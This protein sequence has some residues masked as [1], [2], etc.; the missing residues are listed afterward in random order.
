MTKTTTK[1][2]AKDRLPTRFN[3]AGV[4]VCLRLIELVRVPD[5]RRG[6][7]E[8][9][10]TAAQTFAGLAFD[11]NLNPR[12]V[13]RALADLQ[14]DGIIVE[15]ENTK[16]SF[17][18]NPEGIDMLESK[19]FSER[20]SALEQKILNTWRM[21]FTRSNGQSYKWPSTH[22]APTEEGAQTCACVGFCSH[23]SV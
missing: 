11:T 7:I 6:N 19:Y 18:I 21:R 4:A 5:W 2:R 12:T 16:L 13:K 3:K 23:P 22:P 17:R 9:F 15:H 10:Y 20:G 8:G 14:R 1:N